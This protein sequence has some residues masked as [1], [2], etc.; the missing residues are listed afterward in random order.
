MKIL[1]IL[2]LIINAI[3]PYFKGSFYPS[4][5]KETEDFIANH[6]KS[7]KDKKSYQD[8]VVMI[9]PHAGYIYSGKI[10]AQGYAVIPKADTYF[11]ISPSHRHW[12]DGAVV[13]SSNFS[14]F[15][16]EIETDKIIIKK[17]TE[18]SDLFKDDC[19]KFE[20]EHAV[21]V[22]LPFLNYK[23][24]KNFKIVPLLINTQ[25]L[26]KI[27]KIAGKI[28]NTSDTSNKKVFYIISSDLSH[29]PKYEKA[30]IL[31][32]TLIEAIKSM[33]IFY[34]DLTSKLM[35]SKKIENFQTL[36]CGLAGIM[37]GVEIAKLFIENPS[38]DVVAY[39]NSYD[40]NPS[41][42]DKK[43]VVGYLTA[44]F[45]PRKENTIK[46]KL[47]K[48][49]KRQLLFMARKSI[50]EAFE[51]KE[52]NFGD[53]YDNLKFNL[54]TAVFITLTQN[55]NLR[56]CMGSTEPRLAL[57]DAVKYFARVSAFADP[58]FTPLTKEELNKIEIE[59]SVLSPLKKIKDYTEIREKKDGVVIVSKKGSGVFLPQ[60]WDFFSNRDEFLSELCSQKAGLWRSCYK[61]KETEIFVFEVEKFS[62]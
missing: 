9:A 57:G 5:Q 58:R 8:A 27:K 61:D 28:K 48:E 41:M 19:S 11:I 24:K 13:C 42:A 51:S 25:D 6:F 3:G 45:V 1:F 29:Y 38:L 14:I 35:L 34:I 55:K 16:T 53:L 20:Y 36:A 26:N 40:E 62:E 52:L 50:E 31:D 4:S 32:S 49:E 22:H 30:K 56:G 46:E 59:I 12:F 47:S 44:F 54:P 7:I 15:N 21:E 17:L 60:V 43:S 2:S 10:A 37:L 18:N 39:S 23:F 33:D